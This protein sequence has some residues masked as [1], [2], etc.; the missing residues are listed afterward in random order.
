[1]AGMLFFASLAATVGM[2]NRFF[3]NPE[4][5]NYGFTEPPLEMSL[6]QNLVGLSS[7]SFILFSKMVFLYLPLD[8]I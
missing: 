1:M 4:Y 3:K 6:Y 5:M 7:D 2:P 8:I